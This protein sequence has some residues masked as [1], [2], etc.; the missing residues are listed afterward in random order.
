[1]SQ[2]VVLL[3]CVLI[4]AVVSGVL[5]PRLRLRAQRNLYGA[6]VFD[7]SLR[8]IGPPG[9]PVGRAWGRIA[10]AVVDPDRTLR[11]RGQ[12]V[13]VVASVGATPRRPRISEALW[14]NSW[15][16]VWT[17]VLRDGS[18][19]ELALD[20]RDRARLDPLRDPDDPQDESAAR[21]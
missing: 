10:G 1:V 2:W 21:T 20:R 17:V 15:M 9:A 16:E 12:V 4:G 13:G 11:W 7:A 14:I 8:S 6:T 18:R 5:V 3:V 19:L